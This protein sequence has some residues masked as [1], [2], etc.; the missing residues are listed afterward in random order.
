M[1]REKRIYKRKKAENLEYIQ[2]IQ[3]KKEYKKYRM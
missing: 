3:N 2:R 1:S